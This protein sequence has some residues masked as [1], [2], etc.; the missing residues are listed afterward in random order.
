MSRRINES[1]RVLNFFKMADL[2]KAEVLY[3]LVR[4]TMEQR[5]APAKAAK[6]AAAKKRVRPDKPAETAN[7]VLQRPH[8]A[9]R[10]DG[11]VSA[12]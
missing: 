7:P 3:D 10:G 8:V 6:K 11:G 4:E 1:A 9:D 2:G 12:G 5:L